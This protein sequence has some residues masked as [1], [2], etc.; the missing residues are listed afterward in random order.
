MA[1]VLRTAEGLP[2]LK[3]LDIIFKAHDVMGG[4]L[5]AA[6]LICPAMGAKQWFGVRNEPKN[7]GTDRGRITGNLEAGQRVLLVEDVCTSGGSL[8]R[9]IGAVKNLGA[10]PVA[11]FTIVDR[12]KYGGIQKVADMH[13][14]PVGAAYSL[15]ENDVYANFVEGKIG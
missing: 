13:K 5:S 10:V 4:P 2:A 9:A 1:K 14:I 7:R 15:Q 11:A 12:P 8:I 3:T 6:D